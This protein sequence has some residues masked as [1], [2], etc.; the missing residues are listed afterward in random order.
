MIEA[1]IA[2]RIPRMWL[3]DMPKRH[4]VSIKV[5][6]RR[7]S[8]E[9]GV[10]DLVEVTGP[11]DGLESFLEEVA[12]DPWVTHHDLGFVDKRRLMGD[13]VTRKCLACAALARS[14]S[15]LMS[16][17]VREDGAIVWRLLARDRDE[18]SNLLSLLGD[19]RCETELLKVTSLDESRVL[20]ERQ[21][22]ITLLAFELGYFDTPRRV[23]LKDLSRRMGVS[24]ATLSEILRKGQKKIVVD[25]L[26]GYN[27]RS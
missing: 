19:A 11:R 20:T 3:A 26:K 23:K 17:D 22:E 5:L 10:R 12:D 25:Y 4:G 15:H 16:A 24:Q 8:G 9:E 2:L 13:V 18:L 27:R 14:N 7:P 21:E 1:E 6:D